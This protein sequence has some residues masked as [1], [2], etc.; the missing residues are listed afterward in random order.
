[1]KGVALTKSHCK[2]PNMEYTDNTGNT[3]ISDH[4][5]ETPIF[6]LWGYFH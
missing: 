5:L 6:P 2:T 3:V 4:Q 1:M